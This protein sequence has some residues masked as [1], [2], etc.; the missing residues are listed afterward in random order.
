VEGVGEREKGLLRALEIGV[1]E[2][3]RGVRIRVGT[4]VMPM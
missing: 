3:K 2:E 1:E 4:E